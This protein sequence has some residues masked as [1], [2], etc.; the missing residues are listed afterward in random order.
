[1][2]EASMRCSRPP[3]AAFSPSVNI[4]TPIR[5]SPI[6]PRMR[7]RKDMSGRSPSRAPAAGARR[8]ATWAPRQLPIDIA[9]SSSA[10]QNAPSLRVSGR[11]AG[12]TRWRSGRLD[13]SPGMITAS[14]T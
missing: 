5:K 8:E 13:H 3:A 11:G 14:M 2:A 1:M 4:E 9:A 10:T 12:A 7:M 6:P